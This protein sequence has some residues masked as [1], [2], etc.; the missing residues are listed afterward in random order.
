MSTLVKNFEKLTRPIIF[1]NVGGT[2]SATDIDFVFEL[3]NRFLILGE[4]KEFTKDITIGQE[5][6]TT[7]IVNAWNKI[8]GNIGLVVFAQHDSEDKI[9][10]LK[11]CI[12]NKVFIEGKWKKMKTRINVKD[13]VQLFATKYD[14]KHLK[15]LN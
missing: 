13:F 2:C 8:P 15:Q 3:Y 12:V 6:V 4:I 1:D 14:I 7:R 10:A 11:D 9:I 5:L